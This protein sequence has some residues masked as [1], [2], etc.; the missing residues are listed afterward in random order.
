MLQIRKMR[1]RGVK[2]LSAEPDVTPSHDC[3]AEVLTLG[4]SLL[5][6]TGISVWLCFVDH[7]GEKSLVEDA[8]GQG[9]FKHPA[10]HRRATTVSHS[11][12]GSIYSSVLKRPYLSSCPKCQWYKS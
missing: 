6:E 8:G 12:A 10:V 2:E 5:P 3:R 9:C 11:G 1:L 7:L 4:Q